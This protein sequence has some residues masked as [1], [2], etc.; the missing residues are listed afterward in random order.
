MMT[1]RQ[2]A[3]WLLLIAIALIYLMF[4]TRVYYWDGVT[5]A[6]TISPIPMSSTHQTRA[7]LLHQSIR[8]WSSPSPTSRR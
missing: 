4:P 1:L 3:P 5:F 8:F 6:Q 7:A 2:L